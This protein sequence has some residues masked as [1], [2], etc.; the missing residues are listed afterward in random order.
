MLLVCFLIGAGTHEALEAPAAGD[1]REHDHLDAG[2]HDDG[3]QRAAEHGETERRPQAN[4][5][6]LALEGVGEVVRLFGR[7]VS[8]SI[9]PFSKA[10]RPLRS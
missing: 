2:G 6:V 4:Q 3:E 1:E 9:L 10:A 8:S 7:H 5:V